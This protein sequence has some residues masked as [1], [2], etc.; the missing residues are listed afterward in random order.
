[1]GNMVFILKIQKPVR[2]KLKSKGYRSYNCSLTSSYGVTNLDSSIN[3][4]GPVV[5]LLTH[6]VLSRSRIKLYE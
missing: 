5:R 2:K 3:E 1:M 6:N 4:I